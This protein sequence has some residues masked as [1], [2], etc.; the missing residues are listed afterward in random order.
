MSLNP[1]LSSRSLGL[2][3]QKKLL[4]SNFQEMIWELEFLSDLTYS[5]KLKNILVIHRSKYDHRIINCPPKVLFIIKIDTQ[6]QDGWNTEDFFLPVTIEYISCPEN[7]K[8]KTLLSSLELDIHLTSL[9][10]FKYT[11][12]SGSFT[13]LP[14]DFFLL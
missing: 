12:Q 4:N 1:I 10:S 2:F 13:R 6:I 3:K 14:L 11:K 7:F 5:D 9:G 8:I